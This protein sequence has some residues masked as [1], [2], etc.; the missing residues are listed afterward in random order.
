MV[1]V[2]HSLASLWLMTYFRRLSCTFRSATSK[3]F[4]CCEGNY[5]NPSLAEERVRKRI[6]IRRKQAEAWKTRRQYFVWA[7]F[8]QHH[9]T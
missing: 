7:A 5:K 9:R 8:A 6:Y 1:S 3:A 4:S 2:W